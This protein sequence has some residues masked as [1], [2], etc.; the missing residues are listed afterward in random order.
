MKEDRLG[1]T[2][3]EGI[4]RRI[5]SE[6]DESGL[7]RLYLISCVGTKLSTA[8]AARDLYVSDW[9]R[10]ARAYVEATAQPWFILSAKHGLVHP[11]D[12][13]EPYE[14]TLNSMPIAERREWARAVLAEIEPRLTTARSVVVLAG[15]RYREFLEPALSRRGVTVIVPMAGLRIGEQLSWLNRRLRE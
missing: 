8:A 7:P 15:Q 14:K 12:V 6:L 10:K 13:I 3:A 4:H 2:E 5:D 1:S 9:F 11:A